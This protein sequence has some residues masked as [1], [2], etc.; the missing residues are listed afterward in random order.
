MTGVGP[1]ADF[2]D[3]R[4]YGIQIDVI[5]RTVRAQAKHLR[6]DEQEHRSNPPD[7]VAGFSG[8]S[9][10]GTLG[11]HYFTGWRTTGECRLDE[12]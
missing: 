10:C 12:Y 2:R 11:K 3:R 8:R 1:V 6:V 5:S 7:T 4:L 9:S